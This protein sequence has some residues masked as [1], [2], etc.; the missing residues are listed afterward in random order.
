MLIGLGVLS[1]AMLAPDLGAM[2]AIIVRLSPGA[3]PPP[4]EGRTVGA[5][6]PESP[7]MLQPSDPPYKVLFQDPGLFEEAVRLV[8]PQLADLLDFETATSLDKEHLTA[9][10]RVRVQ[11][12]LRRVEFK[13][14]RLRNGRRRYLLVLLEFQ[15]SHDADMA[16]RMRDY[17][18]QVES[19]LRESGTVRAEGGVPPMLSMVVHNGDRPWRA[20]TELAGPLTGDGAP[21]LMRTYAT[22]DL[23]VLARG[24][25]GEGRELPP[26]SRLATLAELESA[27]AESLPRLLLAA[28]ERYGGLESATLR[29]GLH[30]RVKAALARRGRAEGLPP[31][32]EWERMLAARRGEDMTAMLDATLARWEEAKVAEGM[33]RGLAEGVAQGR[34]ALLRRLAA[35]RFGVDVA[36]QAGALLAD[37]TDVARLDAAGEWLLECDTGDALLARLQA[38][39]EGAGNGAPG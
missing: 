7:A 32:E 17:L 36:R 4:S 18:H 35:R 6:K 37:V 14:G 11:D 21:L 2:S 24:P 12:K 16:W 8:A 9:L 27:P 34:V 15:A 29:R 30:L 5:I 25:D 22:V 28:F 10:D 31:L 13:K 23:Q 19:A 38:G 26:R 1:V 33:E 20:E 39:R 3:A